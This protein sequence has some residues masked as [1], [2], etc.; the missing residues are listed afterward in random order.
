M[1]RRK[2]NLS[3][4]SMIEVAAAKVGIRRAV[5]VM[6]FV[7][8]WQEIRKRYGRD[9]TMGEYVANC[10]ESRPTAYRR[11]QVF[12]EVFDKQPEATP[13]DVIRLVEDALRDSPPKPVVGEI[14]VA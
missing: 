6:A 11:L 5:A 3:A 12:R 2:V 13:N 9:I 8:E 7:A 10:P 14:A 4:A 1:A